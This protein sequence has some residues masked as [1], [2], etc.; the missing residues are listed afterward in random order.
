MTTQAQLTAVAALSLPFALS[1]SDIDRQ[2][3][4]DGS[5]K[6]RD[7]RDP[8]AR[9]RDLARGAMNSQAELAIAA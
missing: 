9:A 5:T 7:N 2:F 3:N 6:T 4:A 8:M 1:A